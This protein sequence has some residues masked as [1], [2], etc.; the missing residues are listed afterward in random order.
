MPEPTVFQKSP[1][2]VRLRRFQ[3]A[4]VLRRLAQGHRFFPRQNRNQGEKK[5]RLVR[6]QTFRHKTLLRWIPQEIVNSE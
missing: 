6:L 5:R 1:I 3:N 4:A 2:V